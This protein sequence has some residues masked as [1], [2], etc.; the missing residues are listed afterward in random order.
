MSQD[1]IGSPQIGT[2]T[3]GTT[4]AGEATTTSND[5]H[6]VVI[7]GQTTSADDVKLTLTYLNASKFF[8][9]YFYY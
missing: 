4:G 3:N 2:N 8:R 1:V 7:I 5:A 9:F 6:L